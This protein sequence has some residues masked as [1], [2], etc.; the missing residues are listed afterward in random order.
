MSLRLV[1]RVDMIPEVVETATAG[2]WCGSITWVQV[3]R[4]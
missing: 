2:G 1:E 4:P 3:H